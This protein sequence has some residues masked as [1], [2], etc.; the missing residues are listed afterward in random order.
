M[1]ASYQLTSGSFVQL[2]KG[3]Y[4]VEGVHK[5]STKVDSPIK[6]GL[7]DLKTDKSLEKEISANQ[8]IKEV[9][10]DQRNLEFLYQEK[11]DF[12]FLDTDKLDQHLIDKLIVGSKSLFLKEGVDVIAFFYE[13]KV[14][15]LELPQ[16]LELMVED[17]A[18]EGSE[19][20]N[21]STHSTKTVILETGAKMQVPQFIE[22][23]D[24]IK[25]DTKS[26]EYIQRV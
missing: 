14:V 6:L 7:R 15:G 21:F 19:E 22:V 9:K 16:F 2:D 26:Q 24:V 3:V 23:G 25:V 17:V 10:L 5:T 1:V 13:G 8:E 11:S 18:E 20:E 4:R 12:L